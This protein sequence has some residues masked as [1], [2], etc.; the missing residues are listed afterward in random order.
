MGGSGRQRLSSLG[1][2]A[3]RCESR[4]KPNLK[5]ATRAAVGLVAAAHMTESRCRAQ[6][7]V[8]PI[9]G[10]AAG[11]TA[12]FDPWSPS[13]RR[14]SEAVLI[15]VPSSSDTPARGRHSRGTPVS[16]G[17]EGAT[18]AGR[19]RPRRP[20]PAMSSL[21]RHSAERSSLQSRAD[22]RQHARSA[23]AR[24]APALR[25]AGPRRQPARRLTPHAT[26][27][28]VFR[29][30]KRRQTTPSGSLLDRRRWGPFRP[31]L[32]PAERLLLRAPCQ[33][34]AQPLMAGS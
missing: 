6:A 22:A 8:L 27:P 2:L 29:S 7:F 15:V 5:R 17:G 12:P 16:R 33:G 18:S 3:V 19:T 32:T 28:P 23:A 31:G 30:A 13:T 1:V 34:D 24:N 21:S 11:A 26:A 9:A 14:P 10:V 25:R 4:H 20:I